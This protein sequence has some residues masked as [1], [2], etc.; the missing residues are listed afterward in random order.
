MT[1]SELATEAAI[2]A[3]KTGLDRVVSATII[4]RGKRLYS[5]KR[6]KI[7]NA[8]PGIFYREQKTFTLTT[9]NT[10]LP[11]SPTMVVP[12]LV[13]RQ[14]GVSAATPQYAPV[15][16]FD[17][18]NPDSYFGWTVI[19]DATGRLIMFTQSG[20]AAGTYRV[21]YLGAHAPADGEEMVL[22]EGYEDVLVMELA[23]WLRVCYEE[24]PRECLA[25]AKMLEDEAD[26]DLRGWHG[27]HP[28]P[29]LTNG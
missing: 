25:E 29:G 23:A 16:V 22:P 1:P 19:Y 12:I 3:N 28:V 6:R 27:A 9:T 17:R 26:M 11:T 10:Y 7:H 2:A 14:I 21:T 20:Q 18:G 24:S 8:F 13:E 4:A 5:R 15:R